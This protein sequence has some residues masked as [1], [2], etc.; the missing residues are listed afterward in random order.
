[1]SAGRFEVDGRVFFNQSDYQAALRDSE[2]IKKIKTTYDLKNPDD[3]RQVYA[4]MAGGSYRFESIIGDDF[5]DEIYTLFS[6][7]KEMPQSKAVE[8]KNTKKIMRKCQY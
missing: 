8:K 2:K 4:L 3:I 1:M 7:I 5:D 6:K